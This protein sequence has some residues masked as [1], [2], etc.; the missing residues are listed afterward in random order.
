MINIT[1]KHNCCGCGACVQK[2]PKQ[3]ISL[4]EDNE[5]FLYPKVDTSVCIDCG[6]CEKVCPVL[7]PFDTRKPFQV[8]AAINKNEQIRM[9]SSSGGIFTLLAEKVI[10]EA[11]V[12]FGARFDENWQVTLDYT[13]TIE[14]LAAFRG[15]KYVQARTGETY[16][17]CEKFLKDGRK[18]LFSG[19]PCQVLALKKFLRKNYDNLL[20]VDLACHGVPSPLIWKRYLEAELNQRT[21]HRAVAGKSTV[22][23]SLKSM[24]SIKDIKFREKSDGW[25]KYRFVLTLNESSDE[26]EKSSVSSYIHYK[27]PY[28]QVFNMGVILRPSCYDCEIRHRCKSGSDIT[29][30]DFWGIETLTQ[31]FDIEKGVSLVLLNSEK[32]I[33]LLNGLD[34]E[35]TPFTYE[36]AVRLN[37]GLR[38]T[39]RLHPKREIFFEN[40]HST[41]D[42]IELMESVLRISYIKRVKSKISR[43]VS[44]FFKINVT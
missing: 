26:V 17:Q 13:E 6:I 9:E 5:G 33:G 1:D 21:A 27:N 43:I 11:G 3:C 39:T 19:T 7:N 30:A 32:A 36:D 35:K 2:C 44:R 40:F 34:L 25:K 4:S 23:F 12:V 14:G 16:K 29:L 41:G 8:L 18:I 38:R 10:A 22:L 24:S 28:F 31:D 37:A 42:I 15:S 20:T